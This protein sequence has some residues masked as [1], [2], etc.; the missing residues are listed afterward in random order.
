MSQ[1]NVIPISASPIS[2]IR[3]QQRANVARTKGIKDTE[4]FKDAPTEW[5]IAEIQRTAATL[6]SNTGW[7]QYRLGLISGYVTILAGRGA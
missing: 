1:T 2:N 4:Q 5:L 7:R 6:E 3:L